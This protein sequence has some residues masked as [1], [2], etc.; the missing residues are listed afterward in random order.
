PREIEL[1]YRFSLETMQI[2]I[3]SSEN[4][5]LRIPSLSISQYRRLLLC[6]LNVSRLP[7][8]ASSQ[9]LARNGVARNKQP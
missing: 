6:Y 8:L 9:G 5:Q 3:V 2:Y 1:N 4:L 7:D